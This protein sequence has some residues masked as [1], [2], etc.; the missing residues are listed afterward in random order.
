[1]VLKFGYFLSDWSRREVVLIWGEMSLFFGTIRC[2][3]TSRPAF[4]ANASVSA[5]HCTVAPFSASEAS[6]FL[7]YLDSTVMINSVYRL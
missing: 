4:E 1:M 2:Y 6:V 7:H 5:I 3:M